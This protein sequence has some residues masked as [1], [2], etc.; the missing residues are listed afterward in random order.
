MI[1]IVPARPA[2]NDNS[3]V[4]ADLE[5][6]NALR[7]QADAL[8]NAALRRAQPILAAALRRLTLSSRSGHDPLQVLSVPATRCPLTHSLCLSL[9]AAALHVL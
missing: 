4:L 2:N 6:A 8:Q 5:Q 1:P 3:S 9:Q 7:A